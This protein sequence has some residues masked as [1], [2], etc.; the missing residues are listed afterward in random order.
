[1]LLSPHQSVR[2]SFE[3][4]FDR[5]IEDGRTDPCDHASDNPFVSLETQAHC[6][7][8]SSAQRLM[9][10]LLQFF[11]N[12]SGRRDTSCQHTSTLVEHLDVSIRDLSQLSEA[13]VFQ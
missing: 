5:S 11:R 13:L 7:T 1:M 6:M 2:Q 3:M 10:S 4:A 12:R 9:Q 8:G